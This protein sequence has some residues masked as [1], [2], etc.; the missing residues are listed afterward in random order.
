MKTWLFLSNAS[1]C[2]PEEPSGTPYSIAESQ[3]ALL[4]LI[5]ARVESCNAN[6]SLAWPFAGNSGVIHL[7]GH[8]ADLLQRAYSCRIQGAI[9]DETDQYPNQA[10]SVFWLCRRGGNDG[11]RLFSIPVRPSQERNAGGDRRWRRAP[12][13]I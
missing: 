11:S 2:N 12:A 3:A 4:S 10:V 13:T 8:L 5:G 9:D 1:P 7:Q 6:F